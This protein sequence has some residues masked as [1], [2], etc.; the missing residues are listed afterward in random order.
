MQNDKIWVLVPA[1][2]EAGSIGKMIDAVLTAGYYNILVIN[3]GSSDKTLEVIVTK[4]V[5]V[6]SHAFNRGV[7]A[8]TQTGIT[9]A[10]SL[11]AEIIVTID[12]DCQHDVSDI[13]NLVRPIVNREA[14]VVLGSRFK[15]D[16]KIP[17]LRKIS[18]KLGNLLTWMLFGLW[19]SD[20]QSGLKAFSRKAAQTIQIHSNGFE[21]CSEIIREIAWYKVKYVEVP[22]KV[23]YSE[24][25]MA[26]GQSLAN[27]FVTVSK[28]IIRAL[29]RGNYKLLPC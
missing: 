24:Y 25:S 8:A 3:D 7:G 12:A 1:Y 21:S 2:N 4:P 17:V 11:G 13:E 10:L 27:G 5:Q 19:V 28:L 14:E 26:K 9:A 20:S 6:V 18:N 15:G 23:T 22:I 29:M 16:S